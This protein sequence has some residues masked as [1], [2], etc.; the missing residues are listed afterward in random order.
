MVV[1]VG[2]VVG[3]SFGGDFFDGYG[4]EEEAALALLGIPGLC[5]EAALF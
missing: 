5:G 3:S 1:V 2:V 4:D